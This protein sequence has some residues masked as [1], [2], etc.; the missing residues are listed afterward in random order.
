[1][2]SGS[3]LVD[4]TAE[5]GGQDR[6]GEQPPGGQLPVAVAAGHSWKGE[7]GQ[8]EGNR[9][10]APHLLCNCSGEDPRLQIL[11]HY[12]NLISLSFSTV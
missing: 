11:S 7:C 3:W 2:E 6:R 10:L 5:A 4:R 9:Y 8:D 1:M 12:S